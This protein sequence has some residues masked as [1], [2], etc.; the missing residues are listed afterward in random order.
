MN[1][2]PFTAVLKAQN[3]STMLHKYLNTDL[4]ANA[5]G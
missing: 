4:K 2:T 5:Q 3:M 1:N